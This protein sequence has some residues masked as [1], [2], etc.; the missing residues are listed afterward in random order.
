MSS[1]ADQSG[2][3]FHRPKR[4]LVV[5]ICIAGVAAIGVAWGV[6]QS[7]SQGT[8]HAQMLELL[9]RIQEESRRDHPFLG[10]GEASQLA[11]QLAALPPNASHLDRFSLNWSVGQAQL[12][13]G[14]IEQAL[15][16]M[17]AARELLQSTLAELSDSGRAAD[18]EEQFLLDLAVA[19]LRAG[20]TENCVNCK[21][22]QSCILP[23]R[24]NGIH[25]NKT[26]SR[27]AV[28]YLAMLLERKP[29]DAPA[30][31]LL[32]IAY[33]TL[34]EH[35]DQ[36]PEKFLI[37]LDAFQSDEP[38]PRF[39][40]IASE[41]GINAFNMC[42][43]SIVDD[44]E[45]DGFLD[46]VTSTWDTAGQLHFFH[47]NGNG[48][49][50]ERSDEA[51]LAGLT[52][53]LNLVQA[54][55]DN[56]GDLDVLV[57]RGAWLQQA[58]RHP[59]SLLQNDGTGRFTDVTFRAGLGEVHYPT[60]TAAWGDYDNDG[61]LDLYV[62]N[63][64]APC[65]LFRNN[66]NKT[67]TDVAQQAGVVNRR[68][69][70]GVAWGDY[71]NDRWPDLYVSNLDGENRLYH[72]NRDGT[73]SDL[74]VKL[75]VAR[76]LTSFPTW[77][78]DYNNDGHLDLFVASYTA[79]VEHVAKDYLGKPHDSEL[80]CLYEGD[81]RG[82]FREVAAKRNLSR[83]TQPMGCNFGDLDHDGFPDFYLGTGYPNYEGLMPNL[84]FHNLGGKRF[85]DVTTAGGF[86]HLQKGHG[87][88]FADL[89]NDGDQD[90]YIEMGGAYPGDAFA[91][92]FFENPGFD[93][94]WIC[95]RLV[96][97]RSNRSA[98]GVRI[99]LDISEAGELRSVYKRVTSGGSFGANPLRQQV[100][101]GKAT[102]I[103]LIEI[104]WPT[105]DTTQQFKNVDVDQYVEVVEESDQLRRL[106]WQTISF[107]KNEK[108]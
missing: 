38:F 52:G 42:G 16:S 100:G 97:R 14:K 77:F 3:R 75:G 51:G 73:F 4:A 64:S 55:Y 88:S 9:Q 25:T 50:T 76:P 8:D 12:R 103:D 24:G 31:W 29:N 104:Y 44:F 71:D 105:T 94:H 62:G 49:F 34:G 89:D 39:I 74:G 82:G 45:N 21:N 85:A 6:F 80:D 63:E 37:S 81:G 15:A 47:N 61:D 56:D 108:K 32:N 95:I 40:D 7:G 19:H 107:R 66:G 58:G 33:M 96:G 54:D 28:E 59:N 35:P 11:E 106:P 68:F 2:S 84:M 57:L 43:G 20:E 1:H 67:F 87:V 5:C 46:I 78:W 60:Q 23:I 10:D 83:V 17:E 79:G 65:Q 41:L 27:K 36:V 93:N 70:K 99:R 30:R 22:S 26:G 18:I 102:K 48:T 69:S 92:A 91:N 86:G 13:L 98:I 72:N 53:G 101:L 90:V